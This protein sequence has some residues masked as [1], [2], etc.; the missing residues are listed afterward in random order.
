MVIGAAFDGRDRLLIA[1]LTRLLVA[2]GTDAA[3]D[4]R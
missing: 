4:C 3:F 1:V 2:A